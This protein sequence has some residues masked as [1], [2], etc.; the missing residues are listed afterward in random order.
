MKKWTDQE[1]QSLIK[2]VEA[3]YAPVKKSEEEEKK[4]PILDAPKEEALPA[5]EDAPALPPVEE[6]AP[7][8]EAKPSEELS[9]LEEKPME[10]KPSEE[11]D[12]DFD[13][14]DKKELQELYSSMSPKELEAHFNALK[15]A[16]STGDE[17]ESLDMEKCGETKVVKSEETSTN[18]VKS[19]EFESIKKENDSLKKTMEE[20]NKVL[21]LVRNRV[22]APQR[23]VVTEMASIQKSEEAQAT[24]S[25][26]KEEISSTL[27]TKIRSGSLKKSDLE[28]I[29]KYY[30][31]S[32]K[33]EL[34]KHLL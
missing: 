13:E 32:N 17:K 10:E 22:V 19:E 11:A 3:S 16:M 34:I 33:I 1:L 5:Q 31:D 12:L 23:K 2:E 15:A 18:L 24:K 9:P 4:L 8:A 26:T 25:F 6:K 29:N 30:L 27:S 7:E 21:E 14:E 28:A 20:Y